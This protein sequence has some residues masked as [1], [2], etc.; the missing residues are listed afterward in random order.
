MKILVCRDSGGAYAFY[1][2][3]CKLVLS[4]SLGTWACGCYGKDCMIYVFFPKQFKKYTGLKRHL[5]P[6]T[7]KL[8]TWTLPL[9]RQ[10]KKRG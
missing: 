8:M 2:A 3:C 10:P 4:P 1:M 6:G 7:K 9:A 5:K